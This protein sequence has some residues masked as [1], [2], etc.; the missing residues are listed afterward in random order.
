MIDR[1]KAMVDSGQNSKTFPSTVNSDTALKQFVDAFA[2]EHQTRKMSETLYC[3][4]HGIKP[5]QCACGNIAAFA[6]FVRGYRT[7]CSATCPN[8]GRSHASKISDFWRDNPAAKQQM[9]ENK[10]NTNLERYGV[11][12]AILNQS[13]REQLRQTVR[14]RYGVDSVL[15]SPE[16]RERIRQ[17]HRENHGVDYPFQSKEILARASQSF[18]RNH[19]YANDMRI[20]RA[21]FREQNSGLNPFQIPE[22]QGRVQDTLVDRYGVDHPMRSPEIFQRAVSTLERNHG[23]SNPAQLHLSPAA[24]K[25]LAD[26]VALRRELET[27]GITGT[28]KQYNITRSIVRRYHDVHLLNILPARVRSQ[29]EEDIAKILCEQGIVFHRNDT[30]ICKPKQLDFLIPGHQLAIEFNGLYWHSETAGGKDR[31]YHSEKARKCRQ[32]GIQLLTIFE[33][34]WVNRQQV[35]V[36]HI[37]HLCGLTDTVIGAR[38]LKI[39]KQSYSQEVRD[40]MDLHHIQG[41]AP[42]A[43]HCYVAR[44][45]GTIMAAVLLRTESNSTQEMVRYCVN[46]EY[47]FPGLFSRFISAIRRDAICRVLTTTADL[48]WSQGRLYEQTGFTVSH[49]IKPDYYYTDYQVREHKFG[50]RKANIK[51]RF[52]LDIEGKTERM[53]TESLGYD[54]IWDC[55]KI[56]YR[57]EF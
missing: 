56:K 19:G 54:R 1:I 22:I 24:Y 55:G 28:A 43:S 40:F 17:V 45:D 53:L 49:E 6:S 35:I 57:L 13:V 46:T 14:E 25:M 47:S 39:A 42:V 21:A 11:E 52:G 7:F 4:Y 48:R 10:R 37:R 30:V 20:A 51:R 16:V 29:Y 12:N 41:P 27:L 50:F 31:G 2:A 44:L 38:K 18:E 26:P 23:F 8:K 36:N 3:I 15:Q 33:D 32:Q 34:E 5:V 9:L